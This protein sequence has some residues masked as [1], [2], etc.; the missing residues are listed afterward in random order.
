MNSTMHQ[1]SSKSL[2]KRAAYGLLLVLVVLLLLFCMAS[3]GLFILETLST[4]QLK[5]LNESIR[6][7]GFWMQFIRWTLY[8]LM[9][10][11]WQQIINFWGNFRQ[12]DD[13]VI[14]LA[15]KSRLSTAIIVLAVELFLIQSVHVSL[16][17]F[18]TRSTL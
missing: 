11:Y 16:Y 13:A 1:S 17:T 3:L 14:E 12:W 15:V 7:F 10:I 9:F 2:V 5:R 6:N 4:D 8:L 18:F